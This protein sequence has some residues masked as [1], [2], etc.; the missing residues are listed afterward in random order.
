[1]SRRGVDDRGQTVLDYAIGVGIFFVALMFVVAT[2][3]GMFAPFVGTGDTQ[4]A[5]RVATSVATGSLGSPDE[6]YVL[7]Q[8]CTV[9]F[10][11]QLRDG[12]SAPADCRFDTSATTIGEMFALDSAQ[13]IRLQFEDAEGG[14]ATIDGTTLAAGES[15]PDGVSVTIARRTVGIDGTTY[16]LEVHAW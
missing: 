5:D 10:F 4:V 2:I 3:P 11:D 8:R 14:I 16:W 15:P 12:T 1:M 7:D 13:S 9:A 6:P